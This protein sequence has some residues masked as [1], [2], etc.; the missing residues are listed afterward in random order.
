M[1]V[2]RKLRL[3]LLCSALA[4][5]AP[6]R[7]P[8]SGPD[9]ESVDAYVVRAELSSTNPIIA[10]SITG[11]GVECLE[12]D[13]QRYATKS[14]RSIDSILDSE[15]EVIHYHGLAQTTYLGWSDFAIGH[16]FRLPYVKAWLHFRSESFEQYL[17]N[18]RKLVTKQ[19]IELLKAVLDAQLNT[20][21]APSSID[22]M[23]QLYSIKSVLHPEYERLEQQI[24]LYLDAFVQTGELSKQSISY[25]ITGK[26]IAAIEAFEEQSLRHGE[27]IAVQ[28]R[29]FWLTVVI[30]ALAA[31]QA[32]LVK[33]KPLIDLT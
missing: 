1:N 19:R 9:A 22:V 6:D 17:F 15:V 20:G 32:G 7:V 5:A 16:I 26:G 30:A 12:F 18:K 23:V 33:L 21:H 3:K 13:G 2:P 25:V 27:A 4:K 8:R 24:E 14:V 29:M 10:K 28:G 31:I 11:N